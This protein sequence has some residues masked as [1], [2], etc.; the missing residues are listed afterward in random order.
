MVIR[1]VYRENG[2]KWDEPAGLTG[3]H[4]SPAPEAEEAAPYAFR[5]HR[6]WVNG[7][8]RKLR[9]TYDDKLVV[10]PAEYRVQNREV[11]DFVH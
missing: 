5:S 3:R 6:S 9:P 1:R 4:I 2:R 7:P 11:P 10:L 8:E